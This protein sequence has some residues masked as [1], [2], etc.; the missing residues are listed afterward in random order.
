MNEKRMPALFVG[1]G[2]PMNAIEENQ[3][4]KTWKNLGAILP[5]PKAIVSISAHWETNGTFVTGME[6][7]KT[8][9]DFGG[10]PSELYQMQYPAKGN[11]DLA[12]KIA[13]TVNSKEIGIDPANWGLDHGT[14]SVLVHIYPQANI[15]VVQLSLDRYATFEQHYHIAKELSSFREEGIL[16]LCSGNIIHNLRLVDWRNASNQYEWAK[17]VS[18]K[19]KQRILLGEHS[20]LIHLD[21]EDDAFKLAINSAEHY[22]PLLYLLGLQQENDSLTLFNDEILMGSLSMTGVLIK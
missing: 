2:S 5:V 8:I 19:I 15:P 10:F 21:N 11:P 14:W 17:I 6:H 20:S 13:N 18:D 3:F 12:K 4:T 7:P 1:H 16:F 22:I 9:H